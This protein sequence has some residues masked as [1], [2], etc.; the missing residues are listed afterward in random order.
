[1]EDTLGWIIVGVIYLAIL[2]RLVRPSSQGPV[3]VQ[4]VGNMLADLV[5]GV[6][7]EVYDPKTKKWSSAP[8]NG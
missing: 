3:L 8:A 5:R 2:Y 1:M 7:G 4:N 6:T